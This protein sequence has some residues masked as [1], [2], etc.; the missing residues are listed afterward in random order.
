MGTPKTDEFDGLLAGE[1]RPDEDVLDTVYTKYAHSDPFIPVI[2]FIDHATLGAE[3]LVGLKLG[4]RVEEWSSRHK[5]RPYQPPV[6]GIAI[7]KQWREALGRAECHGDWL[8]FFEAELNSRFYAETLQEWVPRF[9]H[10]CGAFLFHGLI[11]TAH[12]S[13][14][15]SHR[16]TPARRGELARGLSLWAIGIK[17]QPVLERKD[18]RTVFPVERQFSTFARAGAATF[19]Q[20]PTVPNLHL[21]TS[22]MAYL[23]LPETLDKNTHR[24]AS[25]SFMKTHARALRD[26]E[27]L[28]K[29]VSRK[30]PPILGPKEM[31]S[32]AGKRDA[33]PAK[34]TEAAL[35]G[36]TL[37]GDEIFLRAAA[38]VQKFPTLRGI[39][40]GLKGA[41]FARF[42]TARA[43]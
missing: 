11:R 38:E 21:V 12:A 35:R 3:A 9:A 42:G 17:T 22:A 31:E 14:A 23:M 32:L 33:H 30:P 1:Q 19:I 37:S 39:L 27:T 18:R 25:E 34:L 41:V 6:Q 24:I 7:G 2:R 8:K 29:K 20:E 16:D 10:D 4:S 26:F 13:R 5:V 43:A 40:G 15:L 36:Y 28:S